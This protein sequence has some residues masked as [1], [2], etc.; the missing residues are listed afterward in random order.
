M[1]KKGKKKKKRKTSGIKGFLYK[2]DFIYIYTCMYIYIFIYF[3]LFDRW[4]T[5]QHKVSVYVGFQGL[6]H[7]II[8]TFLL[9]FEKF[10]C[11]ENFKMVAF[12]F[13]KKVNLSFLFECFFYLFLSTTV[14]TRSLMLT[15]IPVIDSTLARWVQQ[16]HYILASRRHSVTP[17]YYGKRPRPTNHSVGS[18][19]FFFQGSYLSDNWAHFFLFFF[20]FIYFWVF[21]FPFD[22]KT[23]KNLG[24]LVTFGKKKT[25]STCV[26]LFW[27]HRG[28]CQLFPN[29]VLTQHFFFSFGV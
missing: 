24:K 6:K 29:Q 18:R 22:R 15:P 27:R 11:T 28:D 13:Q 1:T 9:I 16:I 17:N 21:S 23:N 12:T 20:F 4:C 25:F 10:Q 7:K 19:F 26:A 8:V 3:Y 5:V 2:F 14:K